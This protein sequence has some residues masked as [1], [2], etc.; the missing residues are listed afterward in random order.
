[1]YQLLGDFRNEYN[2]G[3]LSETSL[4]HNPVGQFD[5]WL[6]QAVKANVSEATAMALS[7]VDSNGQPSSR[8]VL[9][10]AFGDRGFV[11]FTNYQ[12]KKGEQLL[13]NNK[14]SLL[15]F[16]PQLERQ[17]RIEGHVE[18]LC[19]EE[20]NNY[21]KERPLASNITVLASKQSKKLSGR[22]QLEEEYERLSQ[23]F[24]QSKPERP[25]TWGGFILHPGLFEFWQGRP[26]RLHDRI[27][28]IRKSGQWEFYRLYP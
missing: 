23:H 14:A 15:F 25:S 28:Y 16:W 18:R 1:M 12:S 5:E 10:K 21:F 20:S 6:K 24:R 26:N 4:F 8:I 2:L 11:F 7:T 22:K 19:E 3:S 27:E 13:Q 9:L 17:V